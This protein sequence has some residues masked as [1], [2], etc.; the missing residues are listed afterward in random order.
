MKNVYLINLSFGLAGIERRFANLWRALRRRGNVFPILV[1]PSSLAALLDEARLLPDDP[2]GLIVTPEPST[3][4]KLRVPSSLDVPLAIVRSRIAAIGYRSVWSRIRRD[5]NAVVHVGMNTSAI[6]PPDVPA[7]YEC[8]DANLEQFD[9]RHFRRA[10]TRRCIVH[11]QTDRIR[12][13]L[14]CVFASR[15]T[16]WR[17]I[18]SPMYFAQYDEK[19]A[20]GNRDP[21]LI[22]FVGRFAP[23][24]NPMMFIE[25]VAR[26]R[27][28][29]T[30][31]RAIMLGEGPLRQACMAR[32]RELGLE[33]VI[34]IDF[35]PRPTEI[36]HR[37]AVYVSLQPGDNYGSQS[38]LEAM[39][40][41]CAVVA[42]DVGE[43]KKIVTD[44]TG[45]RTLLSAESVAAALQP[46]ISDPN[47]S[48]QLGEEAARIART[49]YSADAYA[50]FLESAYEL[51]VQHHGVRTE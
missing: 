17:T 9:T 49:Q 29:R 47:R 27:G 25:A 38:L 10:S 28:Q 33:S 39:G 15:P 23:E 5:R 21:R 34:A 31:C 37:A 12:M 42:S 43:T 19:R 36:L 32:I 14:D 45:V 13:A 1:I 48:H 2:T 44:R 26:L 46:L 7:V 4:A 41:G 30:D 3:L 24:K 8:V 40:A 51:A 16:R 35:V 50:A 18:T 22:A 6:K 20:N 11:C